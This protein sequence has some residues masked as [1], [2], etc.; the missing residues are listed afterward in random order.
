MPSNSEVAELLQ[1]AARAHIAGQDPFPFK[2]QAARLTLE[3]FAA[4]NVKGVR[5]LRQRSACATC[6]A[7]ADRFYS[8][9][10]ALKIQ[11]IPC[12]ACR[13]AITATEPFGLCRCMY[14]A[15]YRPDLSRP[16]IS[17]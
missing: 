9:A 10:E 13:F 1:A 7:V 4:S 11:P 12:R 3:G 6:Q 16:G 2:Q 8:I 17:T 15:A 5:I 14:V